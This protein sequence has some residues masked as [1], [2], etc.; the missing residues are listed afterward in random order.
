M[1]LGSLLLKTQNPEMPDLELDV[2]ICDNLS[3]SSEC[4]FWRAA[5]LEER[6]DRMR[7]WGLSGAQTTSGN[8]LPFPVSK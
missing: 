6:K 4:F 1:L 5:G 2:K 8:T 3:S 7:H